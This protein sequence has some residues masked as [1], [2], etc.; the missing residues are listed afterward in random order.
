VNGQAPPRVA[1]VSGAAQAVGKAAAHR[2]GREGAA[3]VLSDADA[4]GLEAAA[5]Q[6]R[7]AGCRVL[8]APAEALPEAAARRAVEAALGFGRI[9]ALVNA[10]TPVA[11]PPWVDA[12]SRDLDRQIARGLSWYLAFCSAMTPHMAGAGGGRIVNVVSSAGRYRSAY[13]RYQRCDESFAA[14]ASVEGAVLALTRE[15]AFELAPSR[16]RVN[17]VSIGWIRTD[18]GEQAW[19]KLTERERGFVLEEI[20]LRRL[21]EPDEAAAVI[22]FLASEASSYVTG[23]AIDV[24][25][26]WWMS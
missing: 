3:L 18:L 12:A 25:G 7:A 8:A 24:N 26:G 16:I 10:A 2:L 15:L 6:L 19:R 21:G 9:E 23:A 11:T 20:S 14:G 13:F 17:A 4:A 5:G 1:I 22:Q